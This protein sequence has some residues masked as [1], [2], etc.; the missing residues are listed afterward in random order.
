VSRRDI[1]LRTAASCRDAQGGHPENITDGVTI[2]SSGPHAR[3]SLARVTSS[4][5]EPS[6]PTSHFICPQ[7][8]GKPPCLPGHHP[9]GR[10]APARATGS[11]ATHLHPRAFHN[12]PHA[13]GG[14]RSAVNLGFF[15][16]GTRPAPPKPSEEQ[17]SSRRLHP[18]TPAKT[19]GNQPPAAIDCC[20]TV[21]RQVRYSRFCKSTPT[22]STKRALLKT[23]I[24]RNR[25]RTIHTFH[26]EGAG[27]RPRRPTSS[28]SRRGQRACRS[29]T[30]HAP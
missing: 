8:I 12:G 15:G 10:P 26:T 11:N 25:G 3:R 28:G 9:A 24:R 2:A 6:T 16:K 21:G 1:G 27:G 17:D 5:A 4:P 20:L 7:Q 30:T 13:A 14:R 19:G 22:P 29:S 23:R 18:H